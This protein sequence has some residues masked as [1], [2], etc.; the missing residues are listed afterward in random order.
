[1]KLRFNYLWIVALFVVALSSCA[2]SDVDALDDGDSG[3][4]GGVTDDSSSWSDPDGVTEWIDEMLSELYLY[5]DEYN[6]ITNKDYSLA[7]DDFFE[8]YLTSLT[9]NTLDYKEHSGQMMLYSY[10]EATAPDGTTR[11]SKT[12]ATDFGIIYAVGVIDKAGDCGLYVLSVYNDSP[13]TTMGIRRGIVVRKVNGVEIT[14]DNY[15]TY[16]YALMYPAAGTTVSLEVYDAESSPSTK[17][18]SLSTATYDANPVLNCEIIDEDAKIGYLNYAQFDYTYDSELLAAFETLKSE[19]AESLILDLRYN[20]GGYVMSASTMVSAITD[21]S[22]GNSQVFQY[23]RFNDD[24][25]ANYNSM[26][27]WSGLSYNVSNGRFYENLTGVSSRYQLGLQNKT[28]Y[29]LVTSNTASASEMVVN[30]LRGMSGYDV[31]LVGETTR[32]KNVGMFVYDESFDGYQYTMAPIM[33]ENFNCQNDGG[34]EAGMD[35]DYETF[36][37]NEDMN[38]CDYT[39]DETLI[40]KAISLIKGE[41]AVS[42][43]SRAAAESELEILPMRSDLS[44]AVRARGALKMVE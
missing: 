35:P 32:G 10:I 16:Q 17:S 8:G 43:T 2:D 9:T 44:V 11:A 41:A 36:D 21:T 19:G 27:Q 7:F 28:I 38:Y 13:A 22:V 40:A 31:V 26:L 42:M 14:R 12:T 18:F 6:T 34:Y 25:T 15:S 23:Y 20:L 29:C 39:K 33:F 5:N 24:L 30:A 1:M 4:T 3:V 37:I